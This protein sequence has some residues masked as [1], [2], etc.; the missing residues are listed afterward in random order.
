MSRRQEQE[1]QDIFH[2]SFDISHLSFQKVLH[3][4]SLYDSIQDSGESQSLNLSTMHS[5]NDN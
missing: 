4:G 5:P 3:P 2:L 1:N